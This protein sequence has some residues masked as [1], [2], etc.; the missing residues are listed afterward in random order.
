[1]GY[2]AAFAIV[3]FASRRFQSITML[4]MAAGE[5]KSCLYGRRQL[6]WFDTAREITNAKRI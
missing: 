1:M 3:F 4:G 6:F 5:N 2:A